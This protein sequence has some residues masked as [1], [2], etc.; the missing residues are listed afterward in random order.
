MRLTVLADWRS[1]NF[2][3]TMN[4]P[5]FFSQPDREPSN[6]LEQELET[7][8]SIKKEQQE[9]QPLAD[10]E[11]EEYDFG[12]HN[13]YAPRLRLS[14]FMGYFPWHLFFKQIGYTKPYPALIYTDEEAERIYDRLTLALP[15]VFGCETFT[16]SARLTFD[17]QTEERRIGVLEVEFSEALYPFSQACT[18]LWQMLATTIVQPPVEQW[19]EWFAQAVA[20][21][22]VQQTANGHSIKVENRSK[23]NFLETIERRFLFFLREDLGL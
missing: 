7:F 19:Y 9:R 1:A 4:S 2:F 17:E 10:D 8:I 3:E 18:D 11:E 6:S 21:S 23:P 5:S 13:F 14:S 20:F 12:T 16:V 15:Q 22:V